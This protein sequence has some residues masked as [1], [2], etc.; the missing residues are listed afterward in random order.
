MTRKEIK[1]SNWYHIKTYIRKR[2]IGT[3]LTRQEFI[4]NLEDVPDSTIDSYCNVLTRI[5]ILEK[6]KRA[7]YKINQQIPKE[8]NTVMLN[9]FCFNSREPWKDWFIPIE[10]RVKGFIN[11]Q[12]KNKKTRY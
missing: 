4:K 5:N 8:M 11:G 2:K 12:E 3:I 10:D 1:T 9:D 6:I 7:T